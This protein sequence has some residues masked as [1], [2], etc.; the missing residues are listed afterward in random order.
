MQLI[1]HAKF[2][3]ILANLSLRKVTQYVDLI[4]NSSEAF[5]SEVG[6]LDTSVIPRTEF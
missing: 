1:T 3:G 2:T 6:D 5:D 4:P